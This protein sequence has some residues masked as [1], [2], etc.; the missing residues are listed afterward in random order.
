MVSHLSQHARDHPVRTVPEG[1]G[2][3]AWYS[4]PWQTA[5]GICGHENAHVERV[6]RHVK[7]HQ[8]DANVASKLIGQGTLLPAPVA[9]HLANA[10]VPLKFDTIVQAVALATAPAPAQPVQSTQAT[11][12]EGND[13]AD[14]TP[15]DGDQEMHD[16]SND[17]NQSEGLFVKE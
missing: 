7:C 16:A 10:T 5:T 9:N 4:C 17:S 12:D 1:N 8:R 3:K 2:I 15:G 6:H 11:S 13:E 14:G